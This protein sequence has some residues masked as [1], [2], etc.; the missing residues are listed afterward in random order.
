MNNEDEI[1][2]FALLHVT[3]HFGG[4]KHGGDK[5]GVGYGGDANS[6]HDKRYKKY[7]FS[8]IIKET[9][10]DPKGPQMIKDTNQRFVIK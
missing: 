1:F 7:S 4:W 5:D 2:A 9:K 6:L 3:S 8:Q 10:T